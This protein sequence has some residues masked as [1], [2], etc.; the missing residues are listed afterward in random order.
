MLTYGVFVLVQ[1]ALKIIQKDAG[2]DVAC[3]QSE[4]ALL[5]KLQH[6]YI[7][8]YRGFIETEKVLLFSFVFLV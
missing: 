6:P 5:S 3:V 2:Y 1:V 8:G 7:V 4:V